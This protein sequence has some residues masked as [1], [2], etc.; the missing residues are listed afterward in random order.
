MVDKAGCDADYSYIKDS[1]GHSG[2]ALS[3]SGT[4]LQGRLAALVPLMA[5]PLHPECASSAAGHQRH[6]LEGAAS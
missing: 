2:A 5:D 4:H 3:S 6:Q 1:Q